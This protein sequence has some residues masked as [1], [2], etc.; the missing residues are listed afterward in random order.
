MKDYT[1]WMYLHCDW[2]R[3]R[4]MSP[5]VSSHWFLESWGPQPGSFHLPTWL[6]LTVKDFIEWFHVFIWPPLA[7]FQSGPISANIAHCRGRRWLGIR[8]TC[9]SHLNRCSFIASSIDFPSLPNTTPNLSITHPTIPHHLT[10]GTERR[11]LWSKTA[12][13]FMS[14]TLSDHVSEP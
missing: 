6:K 4:A 1:D 8:K 13:H 7:L 14:S 2:Q 9:P 5:I 12:S 10:W 11:H 3:F